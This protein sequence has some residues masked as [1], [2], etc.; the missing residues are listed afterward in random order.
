MNPVVKTLGYV[1]SVLCFVF[2]G[3]FLYSGISPRTVTYEDIYWAEYWGMTLDEYYAE[4]A[5][6]SIG[7]FIILLF[8]GIGIIV[9]IQHYEKK[10]AKTV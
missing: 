4:H 9:G 8:V 1:G 6:F 5:M 3:L 10:N 7:F 2:G